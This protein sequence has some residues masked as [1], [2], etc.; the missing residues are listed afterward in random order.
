MA[1]SKQKIKRTQEQAQEIIKCGKDPAYFIKK[2]VKISHPVNGLVPFETFPYQ[3]D[4]LEM[5]QK[6][7]LVITNKSRQ[8]GLS[9]ISAA[10]SLWL[11]LF[12]REKNV[13]V[14]ATKLATAQEFMTKVKT[15][16]DSL[17]PWLVMPDLVGES[18]KYLHFSNG[19]RIK[20][21]PTSKDAGRGS[22]VSVFIIDECIASDSI[23]TIRNKN[24]GEI[25][26]IEIS[27]L[28]EKQYK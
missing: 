24:T 2:Y 28:Y 18:V 7:R 21:I 12:H 8:L 9:T 14:I 23:I 6:H 3:D 22:A 11:A 4:C 20:A 10:Y 15:M 16:L 13:V 26:N 5:F 17:P 19:S 27:S 25:K 1:S